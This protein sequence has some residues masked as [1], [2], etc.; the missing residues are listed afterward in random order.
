MIFLYRYPQWVASSVVLGI[1]GQRA[2]DL[3]R[4]EVQ[5]LPLAVLFLFPRIIVEQCSPLIA[6]LRIRSKLSCYKP[7]ANPQ[8]YPSQP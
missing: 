4:A 3:D 5:I 7:W 8:L 2:R 6:T 1:F